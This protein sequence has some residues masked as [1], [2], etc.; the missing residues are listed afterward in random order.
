MLCSCAWQANAPGNTQKG[1]DAAVFL[2]KDFDLIKKGHLELLNLYEYK[3]V[4]TL[5]INK[6][7]WVPLPAPGGPNNTKFNISYSFNL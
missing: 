7:D 6:L 1:Y 4:T 2:S 3:V 5:S